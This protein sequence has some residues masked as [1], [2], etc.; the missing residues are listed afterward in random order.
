MA[1]TNICDCCHFLLLLNP[2][3]KHASGHF[4]VDLLW[5][6]LTFVIAA[7]SSAGDTR[8]TLRTRKERGC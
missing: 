2:K 8:M 3:L 5:Q 1:A 7:T 6:L 4:L